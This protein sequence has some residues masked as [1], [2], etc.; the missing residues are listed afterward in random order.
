MKIGFVFTSPWLSAKDGYYV[1]IRE[2]YYAL[3]K[4]NKLTLT[5]CPFPGA[6]IG[7]TRKSDFFRFSKNLDAL[8]IVASTFY[9]IKFTLSPIFSKRK[10][11]VIWILEAPVEEVLILPW[12]KNKNVFL[13]K[14]IMRLLAKR[15]DTCFCVSKEI[16]RYARRDLK[17]KNTLVLPNGADY[18]VFRKT[19]LANTALD[20]I[21]GAYKIMW[22]GSGQFPWQGMDLVV[23]VARKL[24][25]IKDIVF[26]V[27][28][29]HSWFPLP[30]D[31][32]NLLVIN[33]VDHETLPL[34]LNSADVFLCLYKNNFRGSLYNSPMK[35]FEYM[36]ME[37]PVIASNLGQMQEVITDRENGVLVSNTVE[38][39]CK[40]ILVLKSNPRLARRIAVKARRDIVNIY[41][42]NKVVSR[43][44]KE[45][46]S[47]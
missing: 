38:D 9:S 4:R 24:T 39:V 44:E 10:V 45:I 11:P 22:A 3:K 32:K 47:I 42:W 1:K 28:T 34:Y 5:P 31:L 6:H 19:K 40:K 18:T 37:K 12:F 20:K 30:K 7:Y 25:K 21:K 13:K 16:E 27:I 15:V 2:L 41:N 33:S 29:D 35:L 36:A 14:L 8:I 26:I 23:G 17:I 46:G 43:L